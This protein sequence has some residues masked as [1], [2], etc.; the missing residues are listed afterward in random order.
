MRPIQLFSSDKRVAEEL[1]RIE[2]FHAVDATLSALLLATLLHPTALLGPV[3]LVVFGSG[4]GTKVCD[5]RTLQP[6]KG[7]ARPRGFLEGDTVPMHAKM[8]VPTLM[9]ALGAFHAMF[10]TGTINKVAAP[11][12]SFIDVAERKKFYSAMFKKG[13]RAFIEEPMRS[14][15]LLVGHRQNGGT[16]SGEDLESTLPRI[17]DLHSTEWETTREGFDLVGASDERGRNAVALFWSDPRGLEVAHGLFAP[18]F[19]HPVMRGVQREKAGTPLGA[20]PKL[21]ME[22]DKLH[23]ALSKSG[24]AGNVAWSRSG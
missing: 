1:G 14:E 21:A 5:G 8:A 10:G 9:P 17:G 3:C 7:I 24:S 13:A 12:L 2:S 23:V 15:L 6:G 11:A 19:A 4:L 20:L 22:K 18:P 16:L